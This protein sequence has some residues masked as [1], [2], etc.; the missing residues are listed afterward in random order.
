MLAKK[1]HPDAN[2]NNEDKMVKVNDAYAIL[3]NDDSRKEYD[4]T[5]K[6]SHSSP[7]TFSQKYS[8]F[9]PYSHH[10]HRENARQYEEFFNSQKRQEQAQRQQNNFYD[11]YGDQDDEDMS[12][13]FYKRYQPGSSS[14][15]SSHKPPKSSKKSSKKGT[16]WYEYMANRSTS[17][18]RH[19]KRY[20]PYGNAYYQPDPRDFEEFYEDEFVDDRYQDEYFSSNP[21]DT[22][23]D[24]YQQEFDPN[25]AAEFTYHSAR[26]SESGFPGEKFYD[27]EF[28][29]WLNS[30]YLNRQRAQG[31]DFAERQNFFWKDGAE[32]FGKT[33]YFT[34]GRNRYN[35][36]QRKQETY[37]PGGLTDEDI[38]SLLN[39][40]YL[41]FTLE[42]YDLYDRPPNQ[43]EI[44]L[45]L[46]N[47][48]K[49]FLKFGID[50]ELDFSMVEDMAA[51]FEKNP[52]TGKNSAK[53]AKSK[54]RR[55]KYKHKN[56]SSYFDSPSS[57][58]Y[59]DEN[60]KNFWQKYMQN[61]DK[62][63][64]NLENEGDT[65]QSSHKNTR[66]F[67]KSSAHKKSKKDGK[68]SYSKIFKNSDEQEN[69]EFLKRRKNKPNK[70]RIFTDD[71]FPD[72]LDPSKNK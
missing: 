25:Y 70:S 5:L 54:Y 50:I 27:S 31:F 67:Q 18:T 17:R 40:S 47:W 22:F 30:Q 3:S 72:Y 6:P 15:N 57:E 39:D 12:D 34:G 49:K 26:N 44:A 51:D 48:E 64:E 55:K 59:E 62:S 53:K 7:A 13:Y 19:K 41:D 10:F 28:E 56:F 68:F 58:I 42:T 60:Y 14:K 52:E 66:N 9:D 43:K 69:F 16:S 46:K 61:R 45:F 24:P 4:S 36:Q 1:Y 63:Q 29:N 35:S 71:G 65:G 11:T 8:E 37:Y 23:Y 33:E 32:N 20:D 38:D 21:Y 2:K